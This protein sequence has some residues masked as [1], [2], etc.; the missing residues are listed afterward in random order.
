MND[1]CNSCYSNQELGATSRNL[2]IEDIENVLNIS[3]WNPR[4]YAENG[5]KTYTDSRKETTYKNYPYIWQYEEYANISGVSATDSRTI[6]IGEGEGIS[7]STQPRNPDDEYGYYTQTYNTAQT[8]IQPTQTGWI[9]I[10]TASDFIN[11]NYSQL[12]SNVGLSSTILPAYW[13]GS[14]FIHT[15]MSIGYYNDSYNVSGNSKF[16]YGGAWTTISP[17]CTFRNT[18]FW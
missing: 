14:R 3:A 9:R 18:S 11:A 15:G 12:I 6:Q 16:Y 2:N 5:Y 1:I 7:R 8:Y 17:L 4:S 10:V 13:F